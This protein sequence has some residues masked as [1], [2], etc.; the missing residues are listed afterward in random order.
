MPYSETGYC[1]FGGHFSEQLH[2]ATKSCR[3]CEDARTSARPMTP[4]IN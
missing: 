2:V 4:G 3:E 1:H